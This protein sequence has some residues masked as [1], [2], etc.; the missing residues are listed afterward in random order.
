MPRLIWNVVHAL[1]VL[2]WV[3][4][5]AP[6]SLCIATETENVLST[7]KQLQQ[8]YDRVSPAIVRLG[9]QENGERDDSTA[10]VIV[11]ADGFIAIRPSRMFWNAHKE[12]LP[13]FCFLADGRV[14]KCAT[15]GGSQMWQIALLKILDPGPWPCVEIDEH[16]NV[17]AGQT[18]AR[19]L[20]ADRPDLRS[21]RE[22]AQIRIGSILHSTPQRWFTISATEGFSPILSLGG[23]LIGITT[24]I[25][26]GKEAAC[27]SSAILAKYRQAL[28]DGKNVDIEL[29]ANAEVS[30]A[31]RRPQIEKSE[32]VAAI[33]KAASATV[34]IRHA[35][36]KGSWSGVIVTADGYVATCAHHLELAGTPVTVELSDGRNAAGKVLGAD[37]IADIGMVKIID[38]G[39]WP[40]VEIGNS[41]SV[42][43]D[44]PCWLIGYPTAR[45]ER[46]PLVRESSIVEADEFPPSHLLFSSKSVRVFGGDS[47]GGVFDLR[48]RLIG[49]LAG[50]N[51]KEAGR[52]LRVE[53]FRQQWDYLTAG[54]PVDTIANPALEEFVQAFSPT[55]KR[56]SGFVVEVLGDN[57]P[58]A[59]G[60]IVA[61]DGVI[62][63][64]ASELYGSIAVRLSDGRT[65]P[66][67]IHKVSRPHDLAMIK[68]AADNLPVPEWYCGT[69]LPVG[70]MVSALI[71]GEN[72]KVGVVSYKARP[73]PINRGSGLFNLQ[74]TKNGLEV[75]DDAPARDLGMLIRKG[76]LI[77]R[78]EGHETPDLKSELALLGDGNHAGSLQINA[79]DP[80][81]VT[82]ER[83][84]AMVDLRFPAPPPE[85]SLPRLSSPRCAGFPDVCDCDIPLDVKRCGV[86]LNN[87]HGQV[88][89][90]A[91]ATLGDDWHK[92]HIHMI[93]AAAVRAFIAE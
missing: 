51:P 12:H 76:D 48:G 93:P 54:K 19:F 38:K 32:T 31:T 62:L 84:K 7:E 58:R 71:P 70:T 3:F 69:P 23:Q 72:L 49:S 21:F 39:E 42:A 53:M 89:G 57:K 85:W 30:T 90:I 86:P 28:A 64:K 68:I 78:V 81:T 13:V 55:A 45:R 83:E 77:R 34:R 79:G 73:I 20:F 63:T 27:T 41:F 60:T 43:A 82:V 9:L 52:Y 18:Y 17:S 74:D 50:Q 65:F 37:R 4:Q 22:L 61:K 26:I 5:S 67:T 33:D 15:L 35:T 40:H 91:I 24:S 66:A 29:L 59:L 80:I 11:S 44:D 1:V 88:V 25:P 87:I 36:S 47:G 10:G 56:V 8:L 75:V 2:V 46:T 16:S 14:A 6:R 92:T